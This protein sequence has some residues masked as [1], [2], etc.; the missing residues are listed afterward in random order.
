V[1]GEGRGVEPIDA[2]VI[3]T[4]PQGKLHDRIC[5]ALQRVLVA[6]EGV[7]RRLSIKPAVIAPSGSV[8]GGGLIPIPVLMASHDTDRVCAAAE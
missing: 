1:V 6:L 4:T 2:Q 8:P 5:L 7:E 3:G